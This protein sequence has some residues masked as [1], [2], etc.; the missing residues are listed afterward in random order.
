MG[1]YYSGSNFDRQVKEFE[2]YT[3]Y[4][5]QSFKDKITCY[6]N[7]IEKEIDARAPHEE[8]LRLKERVVKERMENERRVIE[9]EMMRLEKMTQKGECSSPGDDTDDNREKRL[10]KKCVI[11]FKILHTLLEDFSKEDLPNTCF[12]KGF[13]RAFSS[14]FGDDV[15]YFTPRLFFNIDKLEH[16]LNE[17]EFHEEITMVVFKVQESISALH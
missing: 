5:T 7:G 15:E 10:K 17:A 14:F 3:G 1:V 2:N 4:S 16:Q 11:H 6:L 12:S 9:F 13:Q 8:R